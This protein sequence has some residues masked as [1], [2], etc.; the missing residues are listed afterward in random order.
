M[1]VI[2]SR[3]FRKSLKNLFPRISGSRIPHLFLRARKKGF[4][5]FS[6]GAVPVQNRPQNP[7][8]AGCLFSTRKSRF[9]VPERGDFGEE[10]CP[11]KGGAD[12]AKKRKKGCTKKGGIRFR[13]ESVS[14]G[15]WCV[16]GFGAGFEIALEPSKL[17]KQR[18]KPGKGDFYF[19]RQTLVCSK[20][21]F[22]RDL[23]RVPKNLGVL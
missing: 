23:I 21:W 12:R 3:A 20:P 1:A 16:P 13:S 8:A 19:L 2:V 22:K 18:E 11:G 15:V 5:F 17:Q 14:T 10:N 7:A 9:E 4:S 6:C